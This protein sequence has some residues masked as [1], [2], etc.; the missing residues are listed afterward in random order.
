MLCKKNELAKRC[1]SL[2]LYSGRI[3][4][5]VGD[6]INNISMSIVKVNIN[7]AYREISL[8]VC[9]EGGGGMQREFFKEKS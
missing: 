6:L 1:V 5:N 7:G 8:F 3:I 4:P 9:V 2:R